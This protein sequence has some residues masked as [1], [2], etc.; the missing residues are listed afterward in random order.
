MAGVRLQSDKAEFVTEFKIL[1]FQI[2]FKSVQIQL[3]TTDLEQ[4][5]DYFQNRNNIHF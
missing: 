5:T 2:R 4:Q 1:T 3:S